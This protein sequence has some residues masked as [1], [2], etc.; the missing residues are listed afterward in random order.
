MIKGFWSYARRDD[1][2]G[3]ITSLKKA[4]KQSL[5]EAI[6]DDVGIYMDTTHIHWGE[7]WRKAIKRGIEE[8]TFFIPILTP[9]YFKRSHCLFEFTLAIEGGRKI[10]P[11]YYRKV[12]IPK[13]ERKDYSAEAIKIAGMAF[14]IHYRDFR[15]LKNEDRQ[16]KEVLDF[17]DD[18][19]DEIASIA[20]KKK[21]LG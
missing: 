14:D 15:N 8:C 7:Q 17:L 6:G 18:I 10:L 20:F 16:K 1:R 13:E 5:E 21:M 11:L 12:P 2:Y 9:S 3:K 19:S 4:F